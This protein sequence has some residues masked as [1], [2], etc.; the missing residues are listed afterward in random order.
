L[1]GLDTDTGQVVL[2]D[3]TVGRKATEHVL[4][5]AGTVSD[6]LGALDVELGLH[7]EVFDPALDR[8]LP[9]RIKASR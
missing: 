3:V 8:T 9:V 6:L 2:I 7:D 5:N 4:T 1:G